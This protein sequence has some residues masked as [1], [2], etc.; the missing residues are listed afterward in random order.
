MGCAITK[1]VNDSAASKKRPADRES[2]P[3][4]RS[5]SSNKSVSLRLVNDGS[6]SVKTMTFK[7]VMADKLG[8]E[9]F[10]KFLEFEH[11]EENLIFFQEV[12]RVKTVGQEEF[13]KE[14]EELVDSYLKPGVDAEVNVSDRMKTEILRLVEGG[15]AEH[16]EELL[17][18]LDKAQN[19]ILMIMAMGAFPRFMKHKLF[20]EYKRKAH[21]RDMAE[22]GMSGDETRGAE[23]A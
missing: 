15:T 14:S 3:S 4:E 13:L 20:H 8:R 9:Y 22:E 6:A 11:A 19:E 2:T 10:M 1:P 7:H 12:D 17:R 5:D 16:Q 21:E 18:Y 23:K